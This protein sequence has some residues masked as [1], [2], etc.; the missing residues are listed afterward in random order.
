MNPLEFAEKQ[1][2]M[3]ARLWSRVRS[4]G[5]L[6][7]ATCSVYSCENEEVVKA[8]LASKEDS[9]LCLDRYLNA[10]PQGGDTLY[11]ALIQKK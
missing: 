11:A 5:Y 8:F 4:G 7:Y 6:L 2:R 9:H 3:L 10:S 1:G